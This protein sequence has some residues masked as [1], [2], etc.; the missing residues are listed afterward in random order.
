M[1]GMRSVRRVQPIESRLGPEVT[2]Q[3]N[4][5]VRRAE[6]VVDLPRCGW[7]Q[8]I[9]SLDL[10]DERVVDDHVE[11]ILRE[12]FP[13]EKKPHSHLSPNAMPTLRERSLHRETVRRLQKSKAEPIVD[14]KKRPNHRV[15]EAFFH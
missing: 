4:F 7:M 1:G 14:M 5:Q 12:L 3:G 6:I 10:D 13:L 2:Q 15:C 9:A 8:L 11:P